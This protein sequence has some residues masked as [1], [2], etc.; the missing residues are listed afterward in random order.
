MLF[1][2]SFL[3]VLVTPLVQA[4]L[5]NDR[6]MISVL[7]DVGAIPDFRTKF[8]TFSKNGPPTHPTAL[9]L[10]SSNW[11]T[12]MHVAASENKLAALQ[13]ISSRTFHSSNPDS[14]GCAFLGD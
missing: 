7:I 6:D 5:N 14:P 1:L 11:F 4:V 10:F 13:V 3:F 2:L 9:N 8:G 12:P